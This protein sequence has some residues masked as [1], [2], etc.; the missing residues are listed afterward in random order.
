MF[1][2]DFHSVSLVYLLIKIQLI[3]K[4]CLHSYR[5]SLINDVDPKTEAQ[6]LEIFNWRVQVITETLVSYIFGLDVD[7]CTEELQ[8]SDNCHVIQPFVSV[9]VN[10]TLRE[11]ASTPR[12][13][14][15]LPPSLLSDLFKLTKNYC[16]KS[17]KRTFTASDLQL[18][19]ANG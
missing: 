15:A 11:L 16:H 18:Y 14:V 7:W 8:K 10:S 5:N 2:G 1:Q 12:P 9:Q 17:E 19:G 6:D 3:L 4:L 13:A